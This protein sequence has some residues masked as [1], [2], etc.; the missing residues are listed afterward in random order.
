MEIV[1]ACSRCVAVRS[2]SLAPWAG[3]KERYSGT[4]HG[5]ESLVDKARLDIVV[6][7][8]EPPAVPPALHAHASG[9]LCI[10]SCIAE[11][12]PCYTASLACARAA[13]CGL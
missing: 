9:C 8:F 12:H 2:P 11:A 7:R 4:E 13:G 5:T 3:K 1:P 10:C 6:D